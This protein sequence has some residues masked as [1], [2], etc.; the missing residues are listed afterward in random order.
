MKPVRQ[1]SSVS[2]SNVTASGSGPLDAL[3]A[4][5]ALLR[6]L[7]RPVVEGGGTAAIADG[8][9]SNSA[10]SDAELS[11]TGLIPTGAAGARLGPVSFGVGFLPDAVARSDWHYRDAPGGL[12]GATA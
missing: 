4:N 3:D 8:K 5:P 1:S 2:P 10:N 6:E 12:D 11:E 9:F 7:R